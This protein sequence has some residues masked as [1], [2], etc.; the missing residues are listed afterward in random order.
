MRHVMQGFK[1]GLPDGIFSNQKY[2]FGYILRGLS[3]HDVG[4]FYGRLVYLPAIWYILLPFGIF[5]DNLVNCMVIWIILPVLICC[6]EKNL[7]TQVEI[8]NADCI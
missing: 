8:K 5:C 7:A 4:I 6:T 3:M 1:S 2:Q